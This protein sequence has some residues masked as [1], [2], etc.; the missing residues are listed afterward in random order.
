M[1]LRPAKNFD[2]INTNIAQSKP[3]AG[4]QM[5]GGQASSTLAIAAEMEKGETDMDP[6]TTSPG[7]ELTAK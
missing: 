7:D 4:E 3:Q 5:Q 2:Q 6:M 1:L